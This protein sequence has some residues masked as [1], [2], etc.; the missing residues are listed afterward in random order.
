MHSPQ[1]SHQQVYWSKVME[2]VLNG[3]TGAEWLDPEDN[4]SIQYK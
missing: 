2:Q 4:I 3:A 1:P